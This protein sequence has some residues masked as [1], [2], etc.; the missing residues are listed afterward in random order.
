MLKGKKIGPQKSALLWSLAREFPDFGGI[1]S[2]VRITHQYVQTF[3]VLPFC[4]SGCIPI[5]SS[6]KDTRKPSNLLL[7]PRSL[8]LLRWSSLLC[9]TA[10]YTHGLGNSA[11]VGV[12]VT[13]EQS[14]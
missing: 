13:V 5:P 14:I 1:V 2:G 7:R 6:F 9:P 11:C 12:F 8:I 3:T 4:L 10:S